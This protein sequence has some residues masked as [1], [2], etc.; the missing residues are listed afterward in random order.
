MKKRI[1]K[2][3]IYIYCAIFL[4]MCISNMFM[5]CETHGFK[6][7]YKVCSQC[8]FIHNTQ[9]I[10]QEVFVI[11]SIIILIVNINLIDK[12]ILFFRNVIYTNLI[13]MKVKLNE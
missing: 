11:S 1:Y 13:L 6:Y 12:V 2:L 9:E 8:L 7:N 5:N 10:L 3:I 4:F